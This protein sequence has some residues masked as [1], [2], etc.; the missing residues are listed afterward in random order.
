MTSVI[1]CRTCF[2]LQKFLIIFPISSIFL[3]CVI[4]FIYCHCESINLKFYFAH[5]ELCKAHEEWKAIN[6]VYIFSVA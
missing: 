3:P 4:T 5:G 2:Y 6:L 1:Y